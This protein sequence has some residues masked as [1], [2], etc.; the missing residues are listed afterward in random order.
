MVDVCRSLFAL[1]VQQQHQTTHQEPNKRCISCR[2]IWNLQ[3]N[4]HYTWFQV[5]SNGTQ[6]SLCKRSS[7][8]WKCEAFIS[9][10]KILWCLC[11]N[12][13]PAYLHR[14]SNCTEPARF[15]IIRCFARLKVCANELLWVLACWLVWILLPSY[16]SR[17]SFLHFNTVPLRARFLCGSF[18]SFCLFDYFSRSARSLSLSLSFF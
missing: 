16:S 13:P 18:S 15:L 9:L 3:A 5:I 8:W 12:S 14:S 4:T 7:G 2:I 17:A 1:N 10:H 6:F 11:V